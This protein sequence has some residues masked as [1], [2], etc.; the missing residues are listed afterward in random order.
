M[1]E[2]DD[3]AWQT[4]AKQYL[5]RLGLAEWAAQGKPIPTKRR[6]TRQYCPSDYHRELIS[7]LSDNDEE[8][9]KGRKMLSGYA[10]AL[11]V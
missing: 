8:A 7:Y 11:G 6:P 4:A 10:S 3:T 1:A 5:E 9:F 2:Y